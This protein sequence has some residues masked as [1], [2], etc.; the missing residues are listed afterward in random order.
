MAPND[1]APPVTPAKPEQPAMQSG[2]VRAF[3]FLVHDVSRLINSAIREEAFAGMAAHPCDAVIDILDGIKGN[4]ALREEADDSRGARTA[5]R[6][7][8]DQPIG[9]L[10][11]AAS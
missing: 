4:L 1:V 9:K 3:R 5:E 6:G 7:G 2:V 10:A 11:I 8:V